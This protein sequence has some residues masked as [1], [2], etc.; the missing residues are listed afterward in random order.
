MPTSSEE[1]VRGGPL[2]HS[3][4][5]GLCFGP[6]QGS[7]ANAL[8]GE[9]GLPRRSPPPRP[10]EDPGWRGLSRGRI[11]R[12]MA[13]SG[14]ETKPQRP[15]ELSE[16]SR[17]GWRAGGDGHP[18]GAKA[19]TE[20]RMQEGVWLAAQGQVPL[21]RSCQLGSARC[22]QR[23]GPTPPRRAERGWVWPVVQ[24]EASGRV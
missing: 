17:P 22:A 3:R 1:A 10:P 14:P 13:A 12:V 24:A 20:V 21:L 9:R 5:A 23:R 2:P 19:W 8:L 6:L 15:T 16:L 18:T 7:P 11:R 4:A